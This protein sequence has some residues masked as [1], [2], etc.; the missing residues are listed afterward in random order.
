MPKRDRN[1]EKVEID[2]VDTEKSTSGNTDGSAG[3]RA[4][5]EMARGYTF[6]WYASEGV[7]TLDTVDT[8]VSTLTSWGV[9]WY[10]FQEE[11]CKTTGRHHYQGGV[12]WENARSH[13][14]VRHMR[15]GM[16]VEVCRNWHDTV[17]YCKKSET[18]I[19]D[20][21]SNIPGVA[22]KRTL[23]LITELKPWQ[24]EIEKLIL[25]EPDDR[26]IH[27]FWE[28]DGNMGKTVFA[29]YL[30]ANHNALFV[31]GKAS[32]VKYAI[33]KMEPKPRIVIFGFVRSQ[34]DYISYQALEEVKDGI[35]FSP[36]FES[37]M[38][39]FD[40]PHV[41]VFANFEPDKTKLSN[42]RW[43]IVEIK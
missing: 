35:F 1:Q 15:L 18:A 11:V 7:D 6:T 23:K 22:K 39:M 28:K 36:K 33:T 34:E 5:R 9:K 25:T 20:V 16:H 8:V 24:E 17:R 29:K 43:K 27:W 40:S 32:D 3:K 2:T 12:Y 38:V 26:T 4:K 42:D 21:I 10:V 13:E 14:Q 19:G 31:C 41:L 30:C 37:G